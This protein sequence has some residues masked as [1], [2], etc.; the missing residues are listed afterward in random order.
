MIRLTTALLSYENG[1]YFYQNQ[2]FSGIGY[3]VVDATVEAIGIYE[4]G[5]CVA[6]YANEYLPQPIQQFQID[7][8][9]LE[10]ENEDDYEPLMCYEG[11]RYSGMAYDF[12][13]GFCTGELLYINGQLSSSVNYYTSGA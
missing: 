4:Q 8:D 11:Q 5:S 7:S 10:P 2:L 3:H 9:Y 6:D 1:K 13:N 12:H